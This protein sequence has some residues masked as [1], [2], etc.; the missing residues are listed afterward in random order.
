MDT[1]KFEKIR[2]EQYP[3][4]Q[5]YTYLDTST[6]GVFATRSRDAMV[7]F[8]DDRYSEG[9]DM[10]DFVDSWKHADAL[11]ETA[12]KVIN[13][14]ASE[15]FFSASSSEMLNVFTNGIELKEN[16]NII[17]TD[18]AFPSTVYNWFN[19]VGEENVRFAKSE[20]GQPPAE[21]L[22][23]LVDE[24]TA[25]IA[26]C[27]VENT[28]G[29]YHDIKT[30]G[31]FCKSR[32]I[33][34]VL[35]AT[36]CICAMKIDVVEMHIDFLAVSSYK[37]LGGVFG[38]GFSYVSNRILD[39][40]SP[41][42]VGWTGNKNRTD[43]SRYNLDLSDGANR[44]ETGSLN[45]AGLRG[46][47]ESLNIYLELGKDDVEEYILSLVDYL[48]EKV[49]G[50]KVLSL[51]GPFPRERRSGIVYIKFPIEWKLND[52][53]LRENG[54]RAHATN[55]GTIRVGIHFFNNKEDIDKFVNYLESLAV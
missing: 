15:I 28:S 37:W 12:A 16:A 50:S 6:T 43:H 40:I 46:L 9:M 49:S 33:Y 45:W 21:K 44:F 35:D 3:L 20:N 36:Q 47:E 17:T 7:D 4:V 38:V 27:M 10:Y 19:R 29:W 42:Y 8:I 26:L 25:V 18:L 22:F 52:R 11:R 2:L 34:L 24:N 23:D 5:K 41:K 39:K 32:G 30:I 54:I 51:V 48:Y 14:D 1:S 13:A 31:E 55:S 53:I